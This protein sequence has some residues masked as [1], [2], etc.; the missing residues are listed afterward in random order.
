MRRA[1]EW[2]NTL[3]YCDPDR[4]ATS[5][6]PQHAVIADN[7]DPAQACSG[8]LAQIE[9]QIPNGDAYGSGNGKVSTPKDTESSPIE[10]GDTGATAPFTL[11]FPV[12]G[13][14]TYGCGV[15]GG[16]MAGKVVVKN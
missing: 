1:N 5:D 16:L 4:S 9:L 7:Q 11:T 12:P 10:G 8:G 2:S 14:F 6:G 13:T 15:H 3:T